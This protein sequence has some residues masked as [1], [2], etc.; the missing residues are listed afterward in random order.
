MH[1]ITASVYFI[2]TELGT[3]GPYDIDG[4]RRLLALGR[5][6]PEDR[7]LRSSDR[8][9]IAVISLVPD[10]AEL[11]RRIASDRVVRKSS[12]RLRNVDQRRRTPM[13]LPMEVPEESP[14]AAVEQAALPQDGTV[15][16]PPVKPSRPNSES[17][18]V[19]RFF[20]GMAILMALA[21]TV[22][23]FSMGQPDQ[24]PYPPPDI[25][26]LTATELEHL[27]DGELLSRIEQESM[28]R[29]LVSNLDLRDAI[30]VLSP[31]VRHL[32][33][34]V[35]GENVIRSF[36]LQEQLRIERDPVMG[37][38]RS[39]AAM[40]ESYRALN[41]E[42]PANLLAQ[43]LSL[44]EI[45]VE[46]LRKIDAQYLEVIDRESTAKIIAYAKAH[47]REL[48]P[49]LFSKEVLNNGK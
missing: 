20:P 11:Y 14:G 24:G 1:D 38:S 5:L 3:D 19:R 15:T 36:G 30:S 25:P 22:W 28:R 13:P 27:P 10:A 37:G 18:S 40:I 26:A 31:T 29:M 39:L 34:L 7:L 17:Q 4:L 48:F 2:E 16:P 9:V 8:E 47:R 43:A 44:P 32:L 33:T 35:G 21:I 6:S 41:M 42:V 45:Q 23:V 46:S 49:D 12:D